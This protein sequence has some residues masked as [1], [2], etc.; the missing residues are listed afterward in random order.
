MKELEIFTGDTGSFRIPRDALLDL[1]WVTTNE[2]LQEVLHKEAVKRGL[3]IMLDY[4]VI[5]NQHIIHWR[6]DTTTQ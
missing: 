6:P 3:M 4:D 1:P 5:T 2:D